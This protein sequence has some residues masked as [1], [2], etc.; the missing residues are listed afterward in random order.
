M[1]N[2]DKKLVL[3]GAGPALVCALLM[4]IVLTSGLVVNDWGMVLA[5][6]ALFAAVF[7]PGLA[8][9]LRMRGKSRP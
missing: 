9:V 7:F 1:I 5:A 2:Q 6:I 8:N 3:L 4:I